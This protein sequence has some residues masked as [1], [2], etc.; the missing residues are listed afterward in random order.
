MKNA[1]VVMVGVAFMGEVV[2]FWQ[3]IGYGVSIAGFMIYSLV[4]MNQSRPNAPPAPAAMK[5]AD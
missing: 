3:G 1:V 5:K 4:K 2:S